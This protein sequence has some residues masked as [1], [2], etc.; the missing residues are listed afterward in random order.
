MYAD[1][2][3]STVVSPLQTFSLPS[4]D[5]PHVE[6]LPEIVEAEATD[7]DQQSQGSASGVSD[8]YSSLSGMG[9]SEADITMA[10]QLHHIELGK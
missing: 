4:P 9:F 2:Y 7:S 5:V 10:L 3:G 6:D 1:F 8:V